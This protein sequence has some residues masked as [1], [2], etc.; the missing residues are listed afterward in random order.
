DIESNWDYGQVKI[1]TNNGAT[2]IPLAGNYTEP[3]VGS[4]QPNGQPVYDGVQNNWVQ[5][6]ISLAG[7]NSDQ[8]KIRF[9]LVSDGLVNHDCCYR[10]DIVMMV[11]SAVSAELSSF[12]TDLTSKGGILK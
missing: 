7:Y 1:S 11:Y 5:E 10:Y 2:W 8:V 3:G 9:Q 6:S 12:T 4:F